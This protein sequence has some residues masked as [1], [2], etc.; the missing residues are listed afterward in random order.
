MRFHG[1]ILLAGLESPSI[2]R[3]DILVVVISIHVLLSLFEM[4]KGIP[5]CSEKSGLFIENYAYWYFGHKG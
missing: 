1:K 4:E 2:D 3:Q 5:H